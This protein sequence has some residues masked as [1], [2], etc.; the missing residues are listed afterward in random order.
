MA[1]PKSSSFT[2][3]L[4]EHDVGRLQVAVDDALAVR[5]RERVGDLAAEPKDLAERQRAAS[6][7]LRERL[8]LEQFQDEILDA[9]PRDRR[10][11]GRRCAD[12]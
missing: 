10:R 9:R 1:S 8:T 11:A 6:E 5:G 7:P 12:D 3:D 4:R 2:P